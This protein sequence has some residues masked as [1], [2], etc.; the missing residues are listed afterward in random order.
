MKS[1][2]LS[3]CNKCRPDLWLA[4]R[5]SQGRYY[6]INCQSLVLR[7]LEPSHTS[8]NNRQELKNE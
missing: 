2:P 5:A 6:C 4:I 3:S 1:I 8:I 7:V